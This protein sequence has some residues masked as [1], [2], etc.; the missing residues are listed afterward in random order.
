MSGT[1]LA[2]KVE[3][4]EVASIM[5]SLNGRR[6]MHRLIEVSGYSRDTFTA[7]QHETSYL[8]GRRAMGI[9]ITDEIRAACPDLYL[10]MIKEHENDI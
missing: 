4:A 6:V 8:T 9:F 10:K 2:R 1:D 7:S 3:L 5:N